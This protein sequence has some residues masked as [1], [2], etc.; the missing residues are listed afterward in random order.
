MESLAIFGILGFAFAATT[1]GVL[2]YEHRSDVLNG[3]Y[4]EGRE[5]PRAIAAIL[6]FARAIG[7]A[8]VEHLNWKTRDAVYLASLA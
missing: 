5:Q 6:D 2:V 4:I 7:E 1:S 8:M 3:S